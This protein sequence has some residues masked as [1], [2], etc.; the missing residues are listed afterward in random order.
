MTFHRLSPR[1]L[2]V[3]A[4]AV[5]MPGVWGAGAS[6]LAAD[7]PASA[8]ATEPASQPASRPVEQPT[9]SMWE[10][11]HAQV[12]DGQLVLVPAKKDPVNIGNIATMAGIPGNV[13]V[14]TYG[15]DAKVY[16]THM[17][18]EGKKDYFRSAAM[19][20]TE[21]RLVDTIRD[22]ETETANRVFYTDIFAAAT[23]RVTLT[24]SKLEKPV[25]GERKPPTVLLQL[26]AESF[27]ELCAKHPEEVKKYLEP[28]FQDL[29][30][31]GVFFVDLKDA[32]H[33]LAADLP[34]DP[35]ITA[36]VQALLPRLD[37]DSPDVRAAAEAEL[38]ALGDA[39]LAPVQAIDMSKQPVQTQITLKTFLGNA[40]VGG[41]DSRL[42][43]PDFLL[44]CLALDDKIIPALA[45]AKLEK[46]RGKP[47]D[48]DLAAPLDERRKVVRKMLFDAWAA[49]QPA[50]ARK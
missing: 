24:V 47:V 21:F 8:P 22:T 10:L 16:V 2:P 19:Q 35:K 31:G 14:H 50:P 46:L 30:L 26:E 44:L 36:K 3:L 48:M 33:A 45:K 29:D 25:A 38:K 34:P 15:Q 27:A 12:V 13:H 42:S 7:A 1:T 28:I 37:D 9:M 11:V 43:K 39:G 5:C 32:Q 49:A 17:R 23:K 4:L 40:G 6:T 20:D 18:M 41:G